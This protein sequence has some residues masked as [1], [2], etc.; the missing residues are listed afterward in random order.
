MSCT[1]SSFCAA[2]DQEGG[3]VEDDNSEW[4]HLVI[5]GSTVINSV[6]CTSVGD[7]LVVD[8]AGNV[9]RLSGGHWSGPQDIDGAADF[10]GIS[11]ASQHFC[12]A[13]G[14]RGQ[15]ATLASSR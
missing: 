6:S 10:Q 5:D 9:F 8:G 12:A 15:A 1:S 7:C 3:I 14:Y 2:V 13:V 4:N 11:C